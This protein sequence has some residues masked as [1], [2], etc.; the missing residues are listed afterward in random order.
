M[1]Q[2][3]ADRV[4]PGQ[5]QRGERQFLD[6]GVRFQAGMAIDFGAQLQWLAG[7]VGRLRAGVQHRAAVAKTGNAPAV[8]Q[9]GIDAR[10]LRRGI[11]TDAE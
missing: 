7:G 4:E 2:V 3:Q 5:C 10:N 11:G 9:M 1:R 8:E 6:L